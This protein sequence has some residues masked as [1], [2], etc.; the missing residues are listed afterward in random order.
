MRQEKFDHEVSK[1]RHEHAQLE[2]R[3]SRLDRRP[4]LNPNEEVER[5]QLQKLKLLK[6]DR[7]AELGVI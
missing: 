2:E 3:L 6:K 5:K 1:L 7:M 4:Y